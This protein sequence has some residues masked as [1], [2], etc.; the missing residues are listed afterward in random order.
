MD[1]IECDHSFINFSDRLVHVFLCVF[2]RHILPRE[3]VW[4][5]VIIDGWKL[6]SS[7]S[8]HCS[9]VSAAAIRTVIAVHECLESIVL[10]M[11]CFYVDDRLLLI[12]LL[13]L[14]EI[15]CLVLI[16]LLKSVLFMFDND[17]S[18]MISHLIS[19]L[20]KKDAFQISQNLLSFVLLWA[21][22][23]NLLA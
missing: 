23:A 21:T 13:V 19:V 10:R 8:S 12:E 2:K 5:L 4:F 6:S 1:S 18:E 16:W 22:W 20:V 15:A 3:A 7:S 11:A 17:L 9:F 14:V